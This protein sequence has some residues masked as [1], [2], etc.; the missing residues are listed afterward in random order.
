MA[1]VHNT[2]TTRASVAKKNAQVDGYCKLE[3]YRFNAMIFYGMP[4]QN[5]EYIQASSRVGRLH[6]GIVFNCLHPARER[7][8]SHYTYFKKFHEF[9][10]QLI[11]PVAINR[12]AKLSINRTL[13]G[14]FMSVLLQLIANRSGENNPNRYYMLDFV[15]QK[16][17]SGN[18]KMDDFIPI[19]EVAYLVSSGSTVSEQDFRQEIRCVLSRFI[20]AVRWS[21]CYRRSASSATLL[22]IWLWTP[23]AVSEL[24]IFAGFAV[25]AAQDWHSSLDLVRRVIGQA[26][27]RCGT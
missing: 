23:V 5:A 3:D 7:D 16:I 8:Q 22:T 12:W 15:K 2:A 21:H 10:G 6:V 1:V 24:E 13:P 20:D 27:I 25:S 9:L 4:R 19:L 18:L 26:T 11:E 14:L 17:T